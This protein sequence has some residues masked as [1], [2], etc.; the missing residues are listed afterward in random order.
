MKT[1]RTLLALIAFAIFGIGISF[2]Q[3]PVPVTDP[4]EQTVVTT[5]TTE[6]TMPDLVQF[7][8]SLPKSQIRWTVGDWNRTLTVAEFNDAAAAK[9]V[10]VAKLGIELGKIIDYI[11]EKDAAEAAA[12]T[13]PVTPT[14]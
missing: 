7:Y 9:G 6:T 8:Y 1:P 11:R 5:N 3:L 10:D 12:S 4:I 14:P 13:H 2:A